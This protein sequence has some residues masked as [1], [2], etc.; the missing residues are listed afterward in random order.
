MRLRSKAR[1][2]EAW[3]PA[4]D[5][6]VGPRGLSLEGEAV[7]QSPGLQGRVVG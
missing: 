7:P 4:A 5:P 6:T 3:R 1:K 2:E